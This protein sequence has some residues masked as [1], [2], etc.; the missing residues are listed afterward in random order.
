MDKKLFS[1]KHTCLYLNTIEIGINISYVW[2]L[3][4]FSIKLL[5]LEFQIF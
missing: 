5:V 2:E 1:T 3:R 4:I